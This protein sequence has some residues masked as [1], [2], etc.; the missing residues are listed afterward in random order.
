M[1]LTVVDDEAP[2]TPV[3]PEELLFQISAFPATA[4]EGDTI[5]LLLGLFQG[6]IGLEGA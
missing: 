4:Y 2:V 1:V 3:E 6:D 5:A